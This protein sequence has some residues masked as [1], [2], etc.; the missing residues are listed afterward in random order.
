MHRFLVAQDAE[1]KV[2]LSLKAIGVVLLN[3]L[4][5]GAICTSI[6][7]RPPENRD[8]VFCRLL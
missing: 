2:P 3:I 8:I 4:Q 6:H 7:G 5:L 1:D